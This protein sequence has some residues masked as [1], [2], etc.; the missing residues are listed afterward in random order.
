MQ[1]VVRFGEKAIEMR[2]LT[3]DQ[4]EEAL[5]AQEDGRRRGLDRSVGAWL[6]DRGFLDLVKVQ[7]IM[8][9]LGETE[10]GRL[11]PEIELVS[12]L[13]RGTSGAVYRGR[14][15]KMGV[16]VA[17]KIRAP[18]RESDDPNAMRFKLEAKLG[19]RLVHGNIVRLFS[20]GETRDYTYHVLEYV[21]GMAL[22]RMLKSEGRL[23]EAFV[24]EVGQQMCSALECAEREKIVHRDIKPANILIT[25]QSQAKLCDLGLAKDLRKGTYLTADG[26]LLGSPF[27]LAPEYAKTG[28][29]DTRGDLYSL[30]VTLYHCATGF[31]PFPGKTAMEIL[32]RVVR[33]AAP[34]PRNYVPTLSDAFCKVVMRMMHKDPAARFQTPAETKVALAKA[35]DGKNDSG[36]NK[37]LGFFKRKSP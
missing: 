21:E 27:Y 16:D 34:D 11:V 1:Q 35:G 3:V 33:D 25:P 20:A 26:V 17:V 37:I 6:H 4:V 13:G 24:L 29:I 14:S 12:I 5:A 31:V 19:E 32:Q 9:Q 36:V 23:P 8:A 30:G 22:D 15:L 18:R 2:L 10:R 28:D 7:W